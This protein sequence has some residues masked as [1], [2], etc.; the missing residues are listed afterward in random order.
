MKKFLASVMLAGIL[1][2][3]GFAAPAV[4]AKKSSDTDTST[5]S[6]TKVDNWPHSSTIMV[7]NWPH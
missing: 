1:T 5:V 2:V 3:G 6:I 4:A 7:D